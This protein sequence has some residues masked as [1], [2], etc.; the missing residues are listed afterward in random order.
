VN[1]RLGIRCP[2]AGADGVRVRRGEV[3]LEAGEEGGGEGG[4]K[5]GSGGPDSV[6]TGGGGMGDDT[7]DG[8]PA[9]GTERDLGITERRGGAPRRGW[10]IMTAP[11]GAC[12]AQGCCKGK[13]KAL[14][15]YRTHV[16][17][18]FGGNL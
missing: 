10:L 6:S 1:L 11:L 2:T 18:A 14:S 4:R 12:C 9:S 7:G 5:G 3:A 15:L 8:V 13:R 16:F 17:S